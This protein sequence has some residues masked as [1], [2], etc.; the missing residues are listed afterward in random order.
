MA[1]QKKGQVAVASLPDIVAAAFLRPGAANFIAGA[2]PAELVAAVTGHV[3]NS[4]SALSS[5]LK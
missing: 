3:L 5:T 2:M 1:R 4:R